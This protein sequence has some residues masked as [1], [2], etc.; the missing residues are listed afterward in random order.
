MEDWKSG[1]PNDHG[2]L[3]NCVFVDS[4]KKWSDAG[5]QYDRC[6]ICYNTTSGSFI[7]YNDCKNWTA[8]QHFCRDQHTDLISGPDQ[9]N[10]MEIGT[11]S[12]TCNETKDNWWIG[13]SRD[14]WG[15]SDGSNSSFRN[16][17]IS[18]PVL[19]KSFTDDNKDC[20]KVGPQGTFIRDYCNQTRPFICYDNLFILVKEKKTWEEALY[21]CRRNHRD[22]AWF[23]DHTHLKNM[24]QQ[25]AKVADSDAV[26]VGL[27]YTCF[28]EAW[29]WVNGHY[30]S[31]TN[32]NWK[33]PGE[34]QCGVAGAM[35]RDGD[36]KWV[37]RNSKETL[38]FI[39][40][41]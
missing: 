38:N 26:W 32:E 12:C 22:L 7:T 3:E 27:H 34:S 6:F 23:I 5:C 21:Y 11:E 10:Q 31:D 37:K 30:V 15:W 2:G 4:S 20:V 24:A 14:T 8:A 35:E 33:V 39:C 29:I 9:L 41:R 1:E 19:N 40:V 17:S 18:D 28:L 36:N 16:W 25:R 13:L